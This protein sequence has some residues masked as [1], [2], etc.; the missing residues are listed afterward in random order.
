MADPHH[1]PTL[2]GFDV[3]TV[4]LYRVGLVLGAAGLLCL[5]G[6][7]LATEGRLDPFAWVLVFLGTATSI[8]NMHLYDKRIRWVIGV[9]GWLGGVGML[10]AP[11]LPD[12]LAPWIFHAGVGFVFVALS[13]FALKEQF[14][15]KIKFLRLVPL[16]LATS[17]IPLLAGER[18][19][20]GAM[21]ACAGLMVG[22]LAVAKLR[23]PL[24]YDIGDKSAYQI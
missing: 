20:S 18:V 9:A 13:G 24:H 6:S 15:F 12:G 3:F 21:L 10:L 5:S 8:A 14:C 19:I 16:V 11:A 4:R 2:D 22:A 23:M 1:V 7:L 17:L